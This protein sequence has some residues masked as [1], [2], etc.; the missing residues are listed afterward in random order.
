MNEVKVYIGGC[1]RVALNLLNRINLDECAEDI[2]L[3]DTPEKAKDNEDFINDNRFLY[4]E[5]DFTSLNQEKLNLFFEYIDNLNVEISEVIT[6]S[7]VNFSNSVFT[8]TLDEWKDTTN[9]NVTGPL[10]LVKVLINFMAKKSKII[11]VSSINSFYGHADRIDYAAAKASLNQLC[12]NL[13]IE[14]QSYDITVNA[15]LPGPIIEDI[16]NI[17]LEIFQS[18]KKGAHSMERYILDYDEVSDVLLFLASDQ[19]NAINGQL[20]VLDKGL[21]L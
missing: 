2:L 7:G 3:I 15:L 5:M 18:S 11:F 8:L 6:M 10:F 9:V 19:S 13:A 17:P 21:T 1:S 12:R 16:N 20:I 4:Y 14:L